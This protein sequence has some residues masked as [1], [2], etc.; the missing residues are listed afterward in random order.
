[1]TALGAS[2]LHLGRPQ[3][4]FRGILGLRHSWLSREILA[5]GI[6]AKLA[7]A[8]FAAVFA[9][10][11]GYTAASVL[12]L[13]LAVSVAVAGIGGVFC[14][15]MIYAVTQRELWSL[16]RCL[17]RFSLTTALLGV[18]A[19]WLS[20]MLWGAARPSETLGGILKTLGPECALALMVLTGIKLVWEL[21]L[22]RHLASS[23]MT[24]LKRS[25]LLMN[26]Q[27]GD[28]AFARFTIGF[29]GGVFMPGLLL[30]QGSAGTSAPTPAFLVI[31][32]ILV[33]ATLA[34]ELMER[35][36]FFAAVASPRM[37]GAIQ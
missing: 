32:S 4:F 10:E 28:L 7:V 14:S 23:R 16:M 1:L 25:A 2:I 11:F 26:R 20:L 13:P 5:F 29:V 30:G 17:T 8:Y 22:F 33:V 21:S 15:A 12:L 27:L 18:A 6:F 37:P 35:Y 34:G 36:L 19:I 24:S 31:V 3:Y 9:V